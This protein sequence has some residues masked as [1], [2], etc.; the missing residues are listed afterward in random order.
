MFRENRLINI[1]PIDLRNRIRTFNVNNYHHG[2]EMV[3]PGLSIRK[4]D[5]SSIEKGIPDLLF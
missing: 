5:G 2:E 1:I 4:K 3:P